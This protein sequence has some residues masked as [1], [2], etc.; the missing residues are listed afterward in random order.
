MKGDKQEVFLLDKYEF[1][2][3]KDDNYRTIYDKWRE[4][5]II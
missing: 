1:H 4:V 3:L 2:L 5:I